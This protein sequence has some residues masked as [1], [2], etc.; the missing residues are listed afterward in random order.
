MAA[1]AC[2]MLGSTACPHPPAPTPATLF[3]SSLC[4]VAALANSAGVGGGA[5]VVPLLYLGLGFDI[6]QSTALSQAV[7]AVRPGAQLA[8]SC[9]CPGGKSAR[10]LARPW[11]R[12]SLR[13][14]CLLARGPPGPDAMHLMHL[15][16][17]T[18]LMCRAGRWAQWRACCLS[19]TRWTAGGRWWT[20][21]W[22]W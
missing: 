14:G 9:P 10:P 16:H 19:G 7:I 12:A 3:A 1:P 6:K 4:Q 17:L 15:M 11:C 20:T 22:R 13:A 8:T 5:F 21:S 18:H 2:A